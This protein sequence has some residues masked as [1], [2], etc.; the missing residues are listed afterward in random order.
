MHEE[1][2]KPARLTYLRATTD[3][4]LSGQGNLFLIEQDKMRLSKMDT[5]KGL[6]YFLLSILLILSLMQGSFIVFTSLV[7]RLDVPQVP[8]VVIG[9]ILG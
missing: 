9:L 4:R 1:D 3:I 6:N 7:P 2:T 5:S 8:F